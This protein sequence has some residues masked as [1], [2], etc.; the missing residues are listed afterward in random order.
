MIFLIARLTKGGTRTSSIFDVV[1]SCIY[2]I[3][4]SP[5]A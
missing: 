4:Y 3:P 5:K 2:I 1:C